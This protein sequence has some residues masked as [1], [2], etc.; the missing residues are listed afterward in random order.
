VRERV[1]GPGIQVMEGNPAEFDAFVR[2]EIA[3]WAPIMCASGATAE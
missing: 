2:R 1:E 3:R